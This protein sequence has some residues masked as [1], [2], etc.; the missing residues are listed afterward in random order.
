M[1][2]RFFLFLWRFELVFLLLEF[3][4]AKKMGQIDFKCF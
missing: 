4:K 1:L 3:L 2:I